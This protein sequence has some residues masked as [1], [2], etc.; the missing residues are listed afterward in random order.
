MNSN[1]Y[2]TRE[3]VEIRGALL[4]AIII[5]TMDIIASI[6]QFLAGISPA[7][8][9]VSLVPYLLCAGLGFLIYSRKK[10]RKSTVHLAWFVGIISTLF[11]VAARYNYASSYG[12]RYA[13]EALHM[14]GV[15]LVVLMLLQFFYN[16]KIYIFFFVF[17]VANW[18]LFLY[19]AHQNGVYMPFHGVVNGEVIHSV[20]ISRQIY[21]IL[22]MIIA[23][24]FGYRNIT[25]FEKFDRLTARQR[26]RIEKQAEEQLQMSHEVKESMQDL[27]NNFEKQNSIV[28]SFNDKLQSQ[29]ASFEEFSAAIEEITSTSEKIAEAAKDQTD[30]E[31]KIQL[32]INE[33]N[34]IK[35]QTKSKLNST[36][37][38][39]NSVVKQTSVGNE[40]IEQ[41]QET[42]QDI[43]S[44][45]NRIAQTISII[46][47]IADK[48]NLLSL[49]A[50]I[51]AASAGEH[52][53]GFAVVADEVGKLAALTGDSIKEIESV[54]SQ[55]DEK[56]K[57]GV[58]IIKKAADNIKSMIQEMIS[59]SG[60]IDELRDNIFVEEKFLVSIRC[61]VEKNNVLSQSTYNGTEE[62]K[63]ALESTAASLEFMNTEVSDMVQGIQKITGTLQDILSE[64][65]NLMEK[66]ERAS[67]QYRE[68]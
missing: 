66:A 51:E 6:F 25:D 37:E 52:G 15:S 50:S 62:Q 55:N 31:N 11:I 23:A 64:A 65:K 7:D 21:F 5:L 41:V 8:I 12:W 68:A 53:R 56:T 34:E 60:E 45:S 9:S 54:L 35:E 58:A 49:N 16:K 36:L 3:I 61:Q 18:V 48:I 2:T 46:V 1:E 26:A 44:Q 28:V 4:Y 57:A 43:R 17:T 19:L 40:I 33:F 42:I 29:A 38:R 14:Y 27:L 59:S 39:I 32:T 47:E 67:M 22:M 20:L 30:S 63:Q 24:F 13:A 10:E